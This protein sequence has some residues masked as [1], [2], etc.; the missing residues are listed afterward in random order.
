MSRPVQ[1]SL[2]LS[3]GSGGKSVKVT[4]EF[5]SVDAIV[6]NVVHDVPAYHPDRKSV[7]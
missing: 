6:F 5:Q 1:L 4:Y 3:G 2:Y 7:V